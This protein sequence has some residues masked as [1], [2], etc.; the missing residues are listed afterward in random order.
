SPR[1]RRRGARPAPASPGARASG[2]LD[3]VD[4]PALGR[5][6]EDALDPHLAG[7]ALRCRFPLD[8]LGENGERAGVGVAEGGD[9]GT[10]GDLGR[11][12][13]FVL[14]ERRLEG[15]AAEDLLVLVAEVAHAHG[16]DLA[17]VAVEVAVVV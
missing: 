14:L 12:D 4:A 11:G 16:P 13:C 7:L 9:E 2:D 8:R 1:G 5:A 3:P 17:Q 6:H 10:A 15:V